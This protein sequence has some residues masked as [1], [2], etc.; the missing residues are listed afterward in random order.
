MAALTALLTP[1]RSTPAVL[2]LGSGVAWSRRADSQGQLF[3]TLEAAALHQ[4]LKHSSQMA[5]R[6]DLREGIG[7]GGAF[8]LRGRSNLLGGKGQMVYNYNAYWESI[9]ARVSEAPRLALLPVL[10]SAALP[11]RCRRS[12]GGWR[13]ITRSVTGGAVV[14]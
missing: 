1:Q 7:A 3:D 12:D 10:G 9:R 8:Y 2:W 6:R 13:G 14:P 11:G 5:W 4:P